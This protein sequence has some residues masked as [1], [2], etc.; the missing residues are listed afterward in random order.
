MNDRERQLAEEA[1]PE[2]HKVGVVVTNTESDGRAE[3][4]G[5]ERRPSAGSRVARTDIT[6]GASGR[7]AHAAHI[8]DG[9]RPHLSGF[10]RT[11][12]I[13]RAAVPL[14]QKV[15][16]LLDGNVALA[17]ANLLVPRLQAPP[18][19][20]HPVQASVA[21]LGE[22]LASLRQG[23]AKHEATLK[24]IEDEVEAVKDSLERDLAGQKQLKED[25]ERVRT[26]MTAFAV[27]GLLLLAVSIAATVVLLIRVQK[28]L[29]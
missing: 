3:G 10:E 4:T 23:A 16:P 2:T 17:V 26:R 6:R 8:E 15:L 7:A 25:L 9:S 27:V 28:V 13:I 21:Q 12:S 29:P 14:V 22:E 19:D 5:G 1:T 11:F 24:R 18:V 20:L